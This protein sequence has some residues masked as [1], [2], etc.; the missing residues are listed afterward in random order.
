MKTLTL[1]DFG[2]KVDR[3]TTIYGKEAMAVAA[4]RVGAGNIQASEA[5]AKP[6]GMAK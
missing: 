4:I 3:A 1:K 6:E 5:R 2:A